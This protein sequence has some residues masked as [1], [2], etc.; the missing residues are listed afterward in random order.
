[1]HLSRIA[2]KIPSKAKLLSTVRRITRWLDNAA[3][4]VREWYEPIA[5][6]LLEHAAQTVGEIRLIKEMILWTPLKL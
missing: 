1:V 2:S 4:R 5:R 3:L 6:A